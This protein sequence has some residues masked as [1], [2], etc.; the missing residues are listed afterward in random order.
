MMY[1][2]MSMTDEVAASWKSTVRVRV[3]VS[4][5]VRVG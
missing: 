1:T 3:E 2:R 4:V 5:K